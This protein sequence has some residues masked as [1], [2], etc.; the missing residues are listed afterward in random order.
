MDSIVL[1]PSTK[2]SLKLAC[3]RHYTQA[4]TLTQYTHTSIHMYAHIH[5]SH[6]YIPTYLHIL[7]TDTY[8]QHTCTHPR[9]H[10]HTH[11]HTKTHQHKHCGGL[12]MLGPGSATISR[13]GI[14][15][16]GVALLDEVYHCGGGF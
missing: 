12:N 6:I 3:A 16:V 2:Q 15:G 4:H 14:V 1:Q 9:T 8:T 5:I 7:H 10:I 11:N 13:C